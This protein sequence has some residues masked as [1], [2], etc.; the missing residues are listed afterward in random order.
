MSGNCCEETYWSDAKFAQI[1][2]KALFHLGFASNGP[3]LRQ[4]MQTIWQQLHWLGKDAQLTLLALS[5]MHP[6]EIIRFLKPILKCKHHILYYISYKPRKSR[7]HISWVHL[8][9]HMTTPKCFK[10]IKYEYTCLHTTQ[11]TLNIWNTIHPG[12]GIKKKNA[13]VLKTFNTTFTYLENR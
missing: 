9:F 13:E 5:W 12:H 6:L 11:F 8:I 1:L 7:K 4:H 3:C 10:S 2:L